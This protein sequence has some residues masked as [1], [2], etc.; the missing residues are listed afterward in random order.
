MPGNSLLLALA[1]LRRFEA[2]IFVEENF[3]TAAFAFLLKNDQ[4]FFRHYLKHLKLSCNPLPEVQTQATHGLSGEN[5]PDI[6]LSNRQAFIIQENKIDA[7]LGNTQ[8]E[9]YAKQVRGS[10]KQIK[11]LVYVRRRTKPCPPSIAGIRIQ[12][13][14][15]DR[16]SSLIKST[17]STPHREARWVREELR[18]FLEELHMTFPSAL[19]IS[20]LK[21][22]WGVFELQD[23]T[24]RRMIEETRNSIENTLPKT[25]FVIRISRSMEYPGFYI[26]RSKGRRLKKA[27]QDQDLW[28][29][30]GI[31]PYAGEI[32][33]CAE[34]GWGRKYECL[35]SSR[36]RNQLE[37][38]GFEH[39]SSGLNDP[40]YSYESYS[41]EKTLGKVIGTSKDFN[42][43]ATRSATW[44][45][46]QVRLL[47][48]MLTS[49]E[50]TI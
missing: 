4:G 29:W 45:E 39:D 26:Y 36:F 42:K 16:V 22:A 7:P 18:N 25:Q 1:S 8:L 23:K 12:Q 41:I 24:L 10:G 28:A 17:P 32:Y 31:Y 44:F 11:G 6:V 34:I 9:R 27:M 2:R 47:A 33:A 19:N 14:T 13:L 3:L 38:N 46:K 15:W 37:R 40:S 30:C 49:L 50:R 21:K 5:I 43:Q 35:V 20:R 48:R